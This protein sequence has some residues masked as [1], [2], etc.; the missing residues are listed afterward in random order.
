MRPKPSDM[1]KSQFL[2]TLRKEADSDNATTNGVSENHESN[3]NVV[4]KIYSTFLLFVN[5]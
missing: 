5:E 2:K 4:C 3:N 1:K